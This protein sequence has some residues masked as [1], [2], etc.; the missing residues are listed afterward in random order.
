MDSNK[1]FS[2]KGEK[3]KLTNKNLENRSEKKILQSIALILLLSIPALALTI[4]D[5]GAQT[6]MDIPTNCYIAVS[7]NPVGV[8]QVMNIVFWLDHDPPQLNTFDYYGWNYTVA[9]T[10]PEGKTTTKR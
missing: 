1:R 8:N 9:I 5:T 4:P 7:P 10:N 6:V 2:P 3:Y